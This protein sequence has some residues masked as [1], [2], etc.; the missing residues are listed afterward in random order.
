[1]AQLQEE[2]A[3]LQATIRQLES[4]SVCVTQTLGTALDW[5]AAL[6]SRVRHGDLTVARAQSLLSS[7]GVCQL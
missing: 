4:K 1:M 7:Y 3:T 5:N 2:I 6:R